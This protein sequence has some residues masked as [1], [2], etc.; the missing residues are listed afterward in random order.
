MMKSSPFGAESRWRDRGLVLL[1]V[2]LALVIFLVDLQLPLGLVAGMLYV[3]VILL[4]LWIRQPSYPIIAALT[5]TVLTA[6]DLAVGWGPAPNEVIYINRPLLALTFWITAVLVV[7]SRR[8][9]DT[10]A[11]HLKQLADLKYALDQASIVATTDVQGR[12]TYVN[13]TFCR[14]SK[15]SRE[16]L[17][18][19]D[20]RIVNSRFHPPEFIRNL[21]RTIARGQIWQ[22]ELRNLA[23]DGSIYWVDTTIVPFLDERGRPYQYTAIRSDITQRKTAEE[24]LMEQ[25]SLARLGQMSAVVAHEVKNPLTGIR[26]AIEVLRM[27]HPDDDPEQPILHEIISRIDGLSELLR[28]LLLFASP[29]PPR[30]APVELLPLLHEVAAVLK[31]DEAYAGVDVVIGGDPLA[32]LADEELLRAALFNLVLNAAQAMH[33][34]GSLRV[35]LAHDGERHAHITIADTGPGVPADLRDKI[36]EPFFTTKSRGGG[37]GLPIAARSIRLHG[38]SLALDDRREGGT[39]TH[40]RLPIKTPTAAGVA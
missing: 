40:V 3:T 21:W 16:E 28:D 31:R 1:G 8:L 33:G 4:G 27:R 18:G 17:I 5:A 24:R 20:H 19:Q 32:T 14:I 23:K 26:A 22:G 29:R 9:Q 11:S 2:V 39:M 13:D 37:L 12:I 10:A 35:R 30:L 15:Y 6:I 7:R 38:G 25:A 36:F 34:R